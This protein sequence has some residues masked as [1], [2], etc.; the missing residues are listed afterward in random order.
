MKRN[1]LIYI[2]LLAAFTSSCKKETDRGEPLPTA[3]DVTF[4][5]LNPG[6]MTFKV[7]DAPFRSGTYASGVLTMNVK[8]NTDGSFSGF[9]TSSKNWRSYPWSLS[10][11]FVAQG[12]LT[13]AQKQSAIDS[14]IFSV[15]TA[16]PNQTGTYLV[17]CVKDED[18]AITLDR[19]GVVEHILVA[20]TT[21]NYLIETN[22]TEFSGTLDNETQAY[23]MD[24]TKVRNPTIPNP[25]ALMYG[26]F[27]LPGPGGTSLISLKGQEILAK[28]AAGKAA[29][30]A[31]RTAGKTPAEVTADSTTA[32]NATSKGFVK[33]SV[34]GYNEG[35][36]A[37]TV[38]FWLAIRPNVDPAF[39]A[40]DVILGDWYR[41]DLATLGAVDRLVFKLSSSDTDGAGNMR[42]PPYFCLDG[43]R[44]KH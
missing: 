27:T 30:D 25:S 3:T 12:S 15:F 36:T 10:P 40:W 16:R 24:G 29:A 22:G 20:N 14:A 9:A 21:Y 38:D 42:T 39:P 35:K 32:A 4:E 13:A 5:D 28:R 41:M 6:E 34:T 26:R 37:G 1:H 11:D 8:K 19:P 18:A 31:A 33:L 17:G 43:I 23:R 44:I 2:L 7:P